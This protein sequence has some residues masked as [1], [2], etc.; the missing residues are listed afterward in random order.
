MQ[1]ESWK[2]TVMPRPTS[3]PARSKPGEKA[4]TH[5]DDLL[6]LGG[7]VSEAIFFKE[8]ADVV[9]GSVELIQEVFVGLEKVLDELVQKVAGG[10]EEWCWLGKWGTQG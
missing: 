8:C 9:H 10:H 3:S 7:R 1:V 4:C 2:A 6:D 5:L